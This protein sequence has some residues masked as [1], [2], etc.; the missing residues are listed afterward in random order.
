MEGLILKK[1]E[2]TGTAIL[3][4][5]PVVMVSC[6]AP[7]FRKNII[8][9]AW[10][11]NVCS[12]PPLVSISIRPERYS[13][14]IIKESEEFV[15]NIPGRNLLRATDYCGTV[16]GRETDKFFQTGLTAIP[17]KLVKAPLIEEAPVN[18][19]CR[20]KRIISLG[21]HDL[22]IAEVLLSHVNEDCL[23]EKSQPDLDK[24]HA[25][26]YGNGNYYQVEHAIGYYG[27]SQRQPRE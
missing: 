21:V 22:F 3:A 2:K 12:E 24:M 14:A 23:N 4:P 20:V 1:L 18:I 10:V 27:Y 17:G 11:G 25:V 13:N 16:S 19:E 6:D 7:G 8:T 15:I 5:V 9:L 26:T